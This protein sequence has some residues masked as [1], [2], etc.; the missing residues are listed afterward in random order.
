MRVGLI[1]DVHGNLP[2]LEAVLSELENESVDRLVCLGDVA[3]GP[4][5]RETL[6][7]VQELGCPVVLGN[8]DAA[9]LDGLP[10]AEDETGA[11]VNEIHGWWGDQLTARDRDFLR[12]FVPTL[13]LDLG[14]TLV[15]CFHGSPRSYDD[16][17]FATRPDAE[18]EPMFAAPRQ[19]LLVGGHTH[20]QML[21]R[22]ERSLLLNPGAVG[23]PFLDWS[24]KQ[25][26]IAPWAEYAIVTAEG[27]GLHI[28]LRRAAYD[29][30]AHLKA[31][32]ASGM[33]H[34]QWWADSWLIDA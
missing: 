6:A 34:A 14:G 12:T 24:P 1:S 22:W 27:A 23:L 18:L 4:Q 9:Y 5:P 20:V 8:W 3:V 33:P 32:L 13:E 30:V 21:R 17:I 10:P 28:D 31:S 11:I 25:V 2:A 26:R 16:Q 7:R 15:L 29:V 19:P